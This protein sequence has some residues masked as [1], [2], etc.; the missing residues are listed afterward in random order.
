[1]VIFDAGVN[2]GVGVNQEVGV[3]VLLIV[4]YH[5]LE[6]SVFRLVKVVGVALWVRTFCMVDNVV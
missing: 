3:L 5:A 1:M 4:M 2:Q 6:E